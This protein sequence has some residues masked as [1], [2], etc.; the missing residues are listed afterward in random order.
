MTATRDVAGR[1]SSRRP[2]PGHV[3]RW[4]QT[5]TSGPAVP[6][7]DLLAAVFAVFV[8][9]YLGASSVPLAVDRDGR[10]STVDSTVSGATTITGLAAELAAAA[11]SPEPPLGAFRHAGVPREDPRWQ[12]PPAGLALDVTGTGPEYDI[13]LHC[14]D[15]RRTA[16]FVDRMVA[17]FRTLLTDALARPAH[18]VLDLDLI[19]PAER[20]Q[21]T[22]PLA[23]VDRAYPR[24][25]TIHGLFRARAAADPDAPAVECDG[26]VLTYRELDERANRLAR[27][28]LGTGLVPGDRVGVAVSRTADLPALLL[29]ILG[30]GCAYVPFDPTYPA[31]RLAVTARTATVA[32][33]VH[34]AGNRP[35]WTD[36]KT[37]S[38]AALCARAGA[39]PATAPPVSADR[40]AVSHVIFTSG[41]TGVPKGVVVHHRNVVALL[42]WAHEQ[43]TADEVR[44]VLFSTSLNFDVSVFELWCPLTMG[45]CLVVVP[46]VLALVESG[47]PAPTLVSTVP[48]ALA[49]LVRERA[50]P[51]SVR[52]V[53]VAGE[54]L[55]RSV[56]NG[57]FTTSAVRRV[58]N[59]YGPTEDTTYSTAVSFTGPVAGTPTI[60]RPIPN[61]RAYVL[62]AAGR[63]VP[64]GVTGE[65]AL[66]GA[67]LSSGYLGDP[68]RTAAAFVPAPAGLGAGPVLYRTGD[69]V[70][71]TEDGE[72][73]FLGRQD[74]QVKLRGHRIELDEVEAVLRDLPGVAQCAVRLHHDN[75]GEPRL[76]GHVLPDGAH[77]RPAD[78]R[79]RLA[80]V[81]PAHMVPTVHVD[82]A[83]PLT[84]NGKLDRAALIAPPVAGTGPTEPATPAEAA[85]CELFAQALDA[86]RVGPDDS[87]FD[88]GGDSLVAIRLVGRIKARLGVRLAM[89]DLFDA[90][91]PAALC[92][93]LEPGPDASAAA[94][95]HRSGADRVPL[96][97]AQQ[98]LWLLHRMAD[99]GDLYNFPVVVRLSGPLDRD[100]L[101]SALRDVV[102]RHESLRTILPE[103]DGVPEQVV[104]PADATGPVWTI[105]GIDEEHLDEQVAAFAAHRFDLSA[106]R[107][108]RAALFVLGPEENVL[109]LLMH[110]TCSDGWS[111]GTLS[112]DLATA[113]RAR[114]AGGAPRWRAAPVRYTDHAVRQR[115][116][117]GDPADQDSPA[118]AQLRFWTGALRGLPDEV[119]LP[120][121]RPRPPVPSYR[122]DAVTFRVSRAVHER[123]AALA[124][125]TRTT[126]FMVFQ[127]AVA[128]LL[129][130]I[131]GG[132]DVPIG[133]TVA[134]R[135]DEELADVVGFFVNT[136]VLR[137]DV[138][139][140]PSF[141]TVLARVRRADLAAFANQGV[142]FE[143]VV[144]AVN[145]A[146]SAARHPLFQVL[147]TADAKEVPL[148]L[149]GLRTT[150][151]EREFGVA[152]FDLNVNFDV[153]H[154]ADRAPSGVDVELRFA[155]DLFDRSTA[156]AIAGWLVRVLDA[157]TADPGAPV[158]RIELLD[159]EQRRR[160]L[161][162]W[163]DTARPVE[164]TTLPEL[165]RRQVRATPDLPAVRMG[166]AELSYA[167][168]DAKA[169]RV[170]RHLIGLGIGPDDLVG[171]HLP[172]SIDMV[173]AV[174]ATLKAGA[175]YLPLDPGY[176]EERISFMLRDA[177]PRVVL[178]ELPDLDDIAA[179][180]VTD[181]DRVRPLLPHHLCYVIYTS[182]ST[183]R[184]K[185]VEVPV[186]AL[187]NLVAWYGGFGSARRVAQF[188][189]ISFDVAAMEIL[190]ATLSG[191]CLVVADDDTRKDPD[192]LVR[193]LAE[194]RV[195]ELIAPNLVIDAVC[196]AAAR[197]GTTLPA[198][199][200]I[201]QGGE[202]L[203]LSGAL[204]EFYRAR[205]GRRLDNYYGPTETHLATAHTLPSTV[206][207]WRADPP[208]GR[209]IANMR[210]Y[211]LD[212]WGCPVPVGV[213]GEL[214][215][216]G[217]QLARGYHRRPALTASRFVPDPFG[218]PGERMYRTGDLVRWSPAGELLFVG[219]VD[220]QVKIRG[221][222]V[223]T[224]EIEARLREHPDV[225]NAA[226]VPVEDTPGA[227]RLVAYV[228]TGANRPDTAALRGHLAR[229][230]PDFMVPAAYVVLESLPLNPNGKLDR[231]A[232][233]APPT[234]GSAAR[235]PGSDRERLVCALFAEV[236]DVDAMSPDED[237]FA[238]GGHSLSASRLVGLIR[239]RT[240]AE[241]SIRDLFERPTPAG[242]TALLDDG[243]GEEAR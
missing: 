46:N 165:F 243:P 85:L 100:A 84:P 91:T 209:P 33:V 225:A 25:A 218:P 211:V 196:A 204:A 164:Q 154:D 38:L 161:V 86:P 177:R 156:R 175:A 144:E 104:L 51:A 152:K 134:G 64:R 192:R 92:R 150:A 172:R 227:K 11:P 184:P 108:F 52:V 107:P 83:L 103:R 82:P 199:N 8:H 202:A 13:T 195:G 89:R 44:R 131:T 54:A 19:S 117:L 10:L 3:R 66:G 71:W 42:A 78:L 116:A 157:A 132:D 166:D 125:R 2:P 228:A 229:T 121:D 188:S 174:W 32:A 47:A 74:N 35:E 124:R 194:H 233:P 138:S 139:G 21:L 205:P 236:L 60:G 65:L 220:H 72:L 221:F 226:V 142:P 14:A 30:I 40:D 50:L 213:T 171:L 53:N 49:T 162:D 240:G 112:R 224:G 119:G 27:V 215:L 197:A 173:V 149:P 101:H 4:R 239:S 9:R 76:V 234:G 190:I 187:V 122:G 182:G 200:Q 80:E 67:G 140:N 118:A 176:P 115:A 16:S 179:D 70:R 147:V 170:A 41:S 232:L 120:L 201:G 143:Q 17:N 167:G 106:E 23:G 180:E 217:A 136:L 242:L 99:R 77:V 163:N 73:L 26:T 189:A 153:R 169:N 105:T 185:G 148:D 230:L 146:R 15:G 95:A 155:T 231:G 43:Y 222:R 183:G 39:E 181:A 75:A 48:S 87:F 88:L 37:H 58:C 94:R 130:K 6:A 135:E 178:T 111:M 127:A 102:R 81:L 5:V 238:L 28:L 63:L 12:A 7:P 22:G 96:S 207:E 45:G 109:V 69:L 29:A 113:Y 61:T 191:G 68:D 160:V 203:I 56:V 219:R 214:Y 90:P 55:G 168:L 126:P 216:A 158:G 206:E 208:I 141:D 128:V 62:D 241:V 31:A 223:E 212:R 110:H 57:V 34:D 20:A 129:A 235:D 79:A 114:T 159:R 151:H 210:A 145:P 97:F 237:F 1:T 137:T 18:P 98:R 123:V 36:A 93:G 133:T 186:A 193:W 59:L 198:L 24:D